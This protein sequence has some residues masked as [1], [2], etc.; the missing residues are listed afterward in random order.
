MPGFLSPRKGVLLLLIPEYSG[1]NKGQRFPDRSITANGKLPV[2]HF[3][4]AHYL[5]HLS[6]S[7]S[8]MW[9]WNH[10]Q[11]PLSLLSTFTWKKLQ[12]I[13]SFFQ[14]NILSAHSGCSRCQHFILFMGRA[15][16]H[17]FCLSNPLLMYFMRFL[18]YGF[19]E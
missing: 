14:R 8:L 9:A 11:S 15:L 13:W 19:Y 18:P 4:S 5:P 3:L 2:K 1:I 7:L 12:Y 17:A 10:L 16:L 6:P